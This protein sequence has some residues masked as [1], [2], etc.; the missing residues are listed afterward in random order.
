MTC[1]KSFGRS[2]Q[3]ACLGLIGMLT[4]VG[5][6][7]SESR[8]DAAPP[9][10]EAS[11]P[12]LNKPQLNATPGTVNVGSVDVGTVSSALPVSITNTGGVAAPL[13]ITAA[14]AGLIAATGCGATLPAGQSCVLQVTGSPTVV[15]AFQGSVTVAATGGNTVVI[16]VQGTGVAPGNFTVAPTAIDLGS[17]AVGQVVQT[18]VTVTANANLTGLSTTVRGTDLRIEATS[19]CGATLSANQSCTVAV[20]FTAG[21]AGASSGNAVVVSQGGVTKTV[22]ITANV[23]TPAKL[24]ATPATAGLTARVGETSPPQ[25]INIGNIGGM[26]SGQLAVAIAPASFKVVSETCSIVTLA[27]G[28]TCSVVITYSPAATATAPELGTLTVTDRGV[29]ASVATVALSGVP[30]TST[31]LTLTGG[32]ALGSVAPGAIGAEV[33]FTVTNTSATPSGALTA[34]VNPPANI[35]ISSNTCATKTTLAQAETCTI[36]LR[37]T[38]AAGA[39]PAT[40]SAVLTVTAANGSV[41]TSVTGAIVTGGFLVANPTSVNFGSVFVNQ[42]SAVKTVTITNG[43]A[44][45]TGALSVNLTGLGA[46]Q[47]ALAGNTCTAALAPAQSCTLTVQYAPTDTTGVNGTIAVTDGVVSAQIPMVGTGLS[48]TTFLACKQPP[49]SIDLR[50]PGTDACAAYYENIA[51][52]LDMGEQ[53]VGYTT[54]NETAGDGPYTLR[55]V[56]APEATSDS[57]AITAALSGTNAADFAIT[58][59]MCTAALNPGGNCTMDITF[60]PAA[61]GDRAAT[62]TITGAKGGVWTVALTGEG[63]ALVEIVGQGCADETGVALDQDPNSPT[64]SLAFGQ[65]PLNTQGAVCKYHLVV[66]GAT[67]PAATTTTTDVALATS[68]PPDFRNVTVEPDTFPGFSTVTEVT[69]NPCDGQ[70]VPLTAGTAV[71]YQCPFFIQFFP[72]TSKGAKTATVTATAS[73]GGSATVTLN[74]TATGPL[75]IGPDPTEFPDV[76]LGAAS[77]TNTTLATTLTVG[78]PIIG[79]VKTLTVRNEGIVNQGILGVALGGTNAADFGIVDDGCTGLTLAPTES[80]PIVVIFAPIAAGAK[81]ATVT[82]TASTGGETATAQLTGNASNPYAVTVAP[83]TADFSPAPGL[84]PVPQGKGSA[85]ATFTISNPAAAPRSGKLS[86][87]FG[88]CAG[89]TTSTT[90]FEL[91]TALSGAYPTG[92]CGDSNTAQLDPAGTCTIQ[93]RFKPTN[94]VAPSSTPRTSTMVVCV[95]GA[96]IAEIDLSG[97]AGPQL[98]VTGTAVTTVDNKLTVDFGNVAL[99]ASTPTTITV[100]N[101]SLDDVAYLLADAGPEGTISRTGG[102]C[103]VNGAGVLAKSAS[104]TMILTVLLNTTTPLTD[105]QV[106]I[107][108]DDADPVKAATTVSLV[109]KATPVNPAQLELF[110]LDPATIGDAAETAIEFGEVQINN[111]AA[112]NGS[113]VVTLWFINRGGLAAEDVTGAVDNYFDTTDGT[114]FS[115]VAESKGTCFS[116]ANNQLEPGKT[117]SVRLRFKPTNTTGG[118]A[119]RKYARFTLTGK[120]LTSAVVYLGG[121]AIGYQTTTVP[122]VNV[123]GGTDT[124][125]AFPSTAIGASAGAAV[126]FQ[127]TNGTGSGVPISVD[128]PNAGDFTVEAAA[129]AG[130]TA[131]DLG[132]ATGVCQ[133]KVTFLPLTAGTPSWNESSKFRPA[134]L[135][136][137]AA[138]AAGLMG[139]AQQPAKLKLTATGTATVEVETAVDGSGTVD[140]GQILATATSMPSVTFTVTNIGEGMT[141][142]LVGLT[143]EGGAGTYVDASE[144]GTTRLSGTGGGTCPTGSV[145]SC[146]AT[147]AVL[148]SLDVGYPYEGGTVVATGTV[149]EEASDEEFSLQVKV[150]NAARVKIVSG[151]TA[152][153]ATFTFTDT[154]VGT[155]NTTTATLVVSNGD[156]SPNSYNTQ[157]AKGVKLALNDNANFTLTFGTA[158]GDCQPGLDGTFELSSEAGESC[159]VYAQFNPEKVG[160]LTGTV[161]V[162]STVGGTASVALKG[163]GLGDLV[164]A[165]QGTAEADGRVLVSAVIA[166]PTVFVV[167]NMGSD[168]TSLLRT[169]LS[170]KTAFAVI[171]DSCFGQMLGKDQSCTVSV[172]FTGTAAAT[173]VN[174]DLTVSDGS[175]TSTNNSVTA[176][177]KSP[178]SGT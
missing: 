82:V 83:L 20:R 75:T 168:A 137:G 70:V 171:E 30:I 169:S 64:Y 159:V 57:G 24:A 2:L 12:G 45:A 108:A 36:G 23:L 7:G 77:A 79:E 138:P 143:L 152:T 161:S 129:S 136:V 4:V 29:G 9:P 151:L 73:A 148:A 28:A 98:T 71:D 33:V 102:T 113:G 130:G 126:F 21:A 135:V 119:G 10:S 123:L 155:T 14:P 49:V 66:R 132:A 150:V 11:V 48:A 56:V 157:D 121:T 93:A 172:V 117:C 60:T 25:T 76:F 162:T 140:F 149:A 167:T 127:I 90:D 18:T 99:G 122:Y 65:Q 58:N 115:I 88:S 125:Y 37:L 87:G 35:T 131:C 177:L 54:A 147:V 89:L 47:V 40:I 41:S 31:T 61:A 104:C 15:G 116:L 50:A 6:G 174:A 109:A 156:A 3:V 97:I 53:T 142:G 134:W 95:G 133:V 17:L 166:S 62:L 110:G 146:T 55:V 16:V 68:T 128:G 44:T 46:A 38:P 100:T 141:A 39:A 13:T 96:E 84:V 32:P 158:D 114:A 69:A 144:C 72:Q 173:A 111:P 94:T 101:N 91:F 92:S 80:C 59:N 139:Q 120:G 34:A 124:V 145:C 178:V 107:A 86:Y 165:P 160:A 118:T 42:L 81:T 26:A 67:N 106:T 85:W 8:Q 74:G 52:Q 43:G 51:S 170:N 175:A 112:P 164:I 154:Y 63:L 163:N 78:D 105:G 5:C 176:Y 103:L 1:S 27:A 22:P 153:P 19:T